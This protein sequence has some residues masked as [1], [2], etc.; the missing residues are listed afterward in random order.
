MNTLS[1]DLIPV[2]AVV[3]NA[4][5]LYELRSDLELERHLFYPLMT[6]TCSGRI[7]VIVF[8]AEEGSPSSEREYSQLSYPQFSVWSP[9]G[10]HN[11][12]YSRQRDYVYNSNDLVSACSTNQLYCVNTT[13][14]NMNFNERDIFG[15]RQ[16]GSQYSEL[17]VVH[18]NG[19]GFNQY[20][21][22]AWGNFWETRFEIPAS[23]MSNY[24]LV[25]LIT[26]K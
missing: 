14:R 22:L 6:F 10:W 2:K 7:D 8:V 23:R 1:T 9:H 20:I 12:H 5:R 19:G 26:C 4:S 3:N 11:N 17:N 18:Q 16:P 24:P 15:I 13:S 25:G 21:P